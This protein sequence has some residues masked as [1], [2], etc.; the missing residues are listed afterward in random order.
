MNRKSAAEISQRLAEE[1]NQA[2]VDYMRL[3]R[4]EMELI[5]EVPSGIPAPD[6][7][8]RILNAGKEARS[9]FAKYQRAV[10]RYREFIDQRIIPEDLTG[11]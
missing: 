3:Q 5:M 7:M 4:V 8:V 10:K 9:A 2:T 11:G 1:L 6:G